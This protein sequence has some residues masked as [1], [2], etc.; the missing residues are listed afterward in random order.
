MV[1]KKEIKFVHKYIQ[2]R[3]LLFQDPDQQMI[4]MEFLIKN[5]KIKK[6]QID[7]IMIK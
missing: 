4:A 3:N 2:F 1:N 6:Y 7:I 5:I